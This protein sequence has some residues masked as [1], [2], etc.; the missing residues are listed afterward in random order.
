MTLRTRRA[1]TVTGRLR[2]ELA[3]GAYVVRVGA[4]GPKGASARANRS[5]ALR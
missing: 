3:A 2:P 5:F 4:R 1:G